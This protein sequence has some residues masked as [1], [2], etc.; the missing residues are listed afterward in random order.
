MTLR[1]LLINLVIIHFVIKLNVLPI[2]TENFGT[3]S[4][5]NQS[6]LCSTHCSGLGLLS[7]HT[8]VNLVSRKS[9]RDII[10][11][12]LHISKT[13]RFGIHDEVSIAS[14]FTFTY[15]YEVY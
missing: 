8:C 4:A 9:I 13:L 12:D 3:L 5:F 6:S 14:K 11:L 1:A 10:Y 7:S 15:Y 2:L